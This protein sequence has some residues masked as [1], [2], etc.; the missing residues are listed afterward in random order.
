[1]QAHGA[2]PQARHPVLAV[3]PL[4]DLPVRARAADPQRGR[5]EA[6][7]G[8]AAAAGEQEEEEEERGHGA[9]RGRDGGRSLGRPNG[10]DSSPRAPQRP[11]EGSQ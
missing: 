4:E 11:A 1:M 7:R 10:W 8:A 5:L 6:P 3:P 9:H 2:V